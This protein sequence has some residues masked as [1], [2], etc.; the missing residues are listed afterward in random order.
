MVIWHILRSEIW[1]RCQQNQNKVVVV[2]AP[3]CR[4][5]FSRQQFRFFES[6]ETRTLSPGWN[7]D[8]AGNY[9]NF[10]P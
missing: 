9:Q 2:D 7:K 10:L 6:Q 8:L 1:E 5:E 3:V 4:L